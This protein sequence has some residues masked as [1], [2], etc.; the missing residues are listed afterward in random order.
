MLKVPVDIV[1]F[2]E[3]VFVPESVNT[4]EPTPALVKLLEAPEITDEIVRPPVP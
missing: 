4:P 1:V 3:Y 2:P